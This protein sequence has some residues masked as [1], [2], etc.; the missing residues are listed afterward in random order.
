[1]RQNK[2]IPVTIGWLTEAAMP[3]VLRIARACFESPWTREDWCNE[4]APT[5][6][7]RQETWGRVIVRHGMIIGFMAY[8][9][10]GDVVE[11]HNLAVVPLARRHGAALQAIGWL[12]EKHPEAELRVVVRERNL[13]AQLF[14]RA[15]GFAATAVMRDYYDDTDEDGY[16]MCLTPDRFYRALSEIERTAGR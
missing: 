8:R 10:L 14:F 3:E 1:M 5:D 7:G 9:V 13:A 4:L 16:L 12:S 2:L 11:I 6:D 15:C